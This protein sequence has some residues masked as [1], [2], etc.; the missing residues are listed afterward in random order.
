MRMLRRDLISRTIRTAENDGHLKLPA[1]HIEHLRGVID[2]LIGRED[3]EVPRH[4][5]DHRP[6]PS[7]RRSDTDSRKPKLSYGRIDNALVAKLLPQTA[8]DLV[9]A[10]VLGDLLAHDEDVLVSQNFFA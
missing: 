9:R 8:R 2:D 4:E 1:R 6:Q 3:R 5:F 7:H 10:V